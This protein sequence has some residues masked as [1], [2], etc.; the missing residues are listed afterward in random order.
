MAK[1]IMIDEFHVTILVPA[2]LSKPE[3][4]SVLRALK[5]RRFQARL[6][7]AVGNLI[8]QHSSLKAVRFSISR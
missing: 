4:A 3:S 1:T 7:Q 6:R 8:R 5:S 2:G